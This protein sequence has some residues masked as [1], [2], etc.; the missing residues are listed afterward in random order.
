MNKKELEIKISRLRDK[1]RQY[2]EY[3]FRSGDE[4]YVS[5]IKELKKEID[6]EARMFLD[7]EN[8]RRK[9]TDSIKPLDEYYE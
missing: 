1:I 9:I 3:T 6:R 2:E 7:E 8:R 5:K 4:K